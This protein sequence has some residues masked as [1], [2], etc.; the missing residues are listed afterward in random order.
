MNEIHVGWPNCEDI[1]DAHYQTIANLNQAFVDTVR[2][3]G[4]SNGS[5]VLVMPGYNT[6]INCTVYRF[7]R[8]TDTI[9]N[10]MV[11]SVHFYDPYTFTLAAE[12]QTWGAGSAPS[13]DDWAQED[14]IITQ[15]EKLKSNFIDT[16]LPVLIGEWGATHQSGYE[17]YRRYYTEYVAKAA[18]DRGILTI[19]WDNGGRNSG[20][21]NSG[22]FDR[23]GNSQA[24]PEIIGALV[25]AVTSDYSIN[26]IEGP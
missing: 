20:A 25:R 16:G 2:L 3:S 24:F 23:A 12:S 19:I 15:V 8:P 7:D 22:L 1:P 18:H 14:W 4:G 17:S 21:E 5:R 6:D 11:L 10:R 9:A 13:G 26:D